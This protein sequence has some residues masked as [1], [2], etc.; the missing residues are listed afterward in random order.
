MV[1]ILLSFIATLICGIGGYLVVKISGFEKKFEDYVIYRAYVLREIGGPGTTGN[2]QNAIN[3]NYEDI[4]ILAI[5]TN[6]DLN[7]ERYLRN[8][9]S[10]GRG[11]SK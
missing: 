1:E 3:S 4:Q 9:E 5:K 10:K 2:V 11:K 8:L 6:T 7:K